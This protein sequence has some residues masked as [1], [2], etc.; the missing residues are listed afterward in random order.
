VVLV[1]QNVCKVVLQEKSEKILAALLKNKSSQHLTSFSKLF[2]CHGLRR[3]CRKRS[4][5]QQRQ[6]MPLLYA[7]AC[8]CSP[9]VQPGHVCR[10]RQECQSRSRP[11]EG[12]SV[13][14][15]TEMQQASERGRLGGKMSKLAEDEI[16][17]Q[18]QFQPQN[19][20]FK[21]FG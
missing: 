2:F 6:K 16:Y 7:A 18:F 20:I 13:A 1:R 5:L 11:R 19:E 15:A 12:N 17:R 3:A 4:A 14:F 9:A 8:T 10:D 21:F